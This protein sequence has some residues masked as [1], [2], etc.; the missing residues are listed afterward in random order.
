MPHDLIFLINCF[1]S[2]FMTGLIWYVQLVHY[3]SFR[4]VNHMQFSQFHAFH[5][6]RTG[7]I[8]MPVMTTELITSGTLWYAGGWFS[9]NTIGFYLVVAI[10]AATFLLSVPLH[11]LLKENRSEAAIERLISTNWIRT[12]LW[13]LKSALAVLVLLR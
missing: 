12:V 6:M 4:F 7:Y 2:F 5:S 3:P 1:T 11:A 8:V 9:L 10:W 13:T